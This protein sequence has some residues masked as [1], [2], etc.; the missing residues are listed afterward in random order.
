MRDPSDPTVSE[1][2]AELEEKLENAKAMLA[3]SRA[4]HDRTLAKLHD[5]QRAQP[6]FTPEQASEVAGQVHSVLSGRTALP[7]GTHDY[8]FAVSEPI[9]YRSYDS[10]P[11]RRVRISW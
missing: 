2:V 9:S 1:Q 6:P 8:V 5:L 11:F 4:D 3:A 10:A 7:S